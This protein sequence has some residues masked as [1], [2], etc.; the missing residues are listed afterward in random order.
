MIALLLLACLKGQAS[1]P[2]PEFYGGT[3]VSGVVFEFESRKR[4]PDAAITLHQA[5]RADQELRSDA[6]GVWHAWVA[7]GVHFSPALHVEGYLPARHATFVVGRGTESQPEHLASV[8]RLDLQAVPLA[9]FD[10][11]ASGLA[12][13]RLQ[14]DACLIVNTV[15]VPAVGE[16]TSFAEF[17]PLRPHGEPGVV[18]RLEPDVGVDPIYFDER[19]LPDRS[20]EATSR[21][22]GV[23]WLNVPPGRYT[24]AGTHPDSAFEVVS[25]Q[26]DCKAGELVNL[27]P[28]M[29]SG[30]RVR[31]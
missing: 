26:V 9:V 19:V 29:G 30:V 28:P 4:V 24:V 7:D 13:T 18:M 14:R 17:V 6:E 12:E 16:M 1:V 5:G 31:Q 25:R 10:L 11:M 20:L 22:G 3:R 27:N 8:D 2:T 21:D 23:V 15:T